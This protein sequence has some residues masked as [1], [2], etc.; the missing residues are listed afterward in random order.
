M[1]ERF[2]TP[3]AVARQIY[4]RAEPS[5]DL[6]EVSEPISPAD[7]KLKISEYEKIMKEFGI[8]KGT[9]DYVDWK[10]WMLDRGP[11]LIDE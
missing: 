6:K 5:L 1:A 8:Q 11:Q 2:Y 3:F 7:Y 9:D 10:C 4:L